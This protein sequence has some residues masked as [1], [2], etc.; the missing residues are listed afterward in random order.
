MCR[1][2]RGNGLVALS[3][4]DYYRLPAFGGRERISHPRP[5]ACG[6]GADD[7]RGASASRR[8]FGLSCGASGAAGF[9]QVIG[10]GTRKNQTFDATEL[11]PRVNVRQNQTL[12]SLEDRKS[13][14]LN[15]SHPSISYAVFCLKKKKVVINVT[16]SPDALISLVV[17]SLG[18]PPIFPPDCAFPP[19][20]AAATC[21]PPRASPCSLH[22]Y[23]DSV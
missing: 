4:T 10:A 7:R 21:I 22:H 23:A 11:L 17:N 14:R 19:A 5:R 12:R 1:H 13:T 8:P 16:R 9:V 3:P 20:S 15:S 6:G 2:V 18:E